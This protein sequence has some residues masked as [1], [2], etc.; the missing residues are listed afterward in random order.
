MSDSDQGGIEQDWAL[1]HSMGKV[2][3]HS[4]YKAVEATHRFRALHTHQLNTKTL[5]AYCKSMPE[6]PGH[7]KHSLR[8]LKDSRLD[9]P[10]RLIIG[11]RDP[12]SRNMSAFFENLERFGLHDDGAYDMD[13]L[14][15]IFMQKYPHHIPINWF[16]T[17][18]TIPLGL[19]LFEEKWGIPRRAQIGRFDVLVDR[20]EDSDEDREQTLRDFLE[21]PELKLNQ[22]NVGQEKPYS[23]LYSAFKA[24]FRPSTAMLNMLFNSDYVRCFYSKEERDTMRNRWC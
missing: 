9:E 19:K 5:A 8:F 3:S 21:C 7:I 20:L 2:G 22:I 15:T 12:M 14:I 4:V 24:Q 13:E 11:I 10:I 18:V 16:K 1:V 17:Q 6:T 23:E